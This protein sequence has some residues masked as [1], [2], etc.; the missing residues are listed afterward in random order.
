MLFYVISGESDDEPIGRI[1]NS[2]RKAR[3][4]TD[5]ESNISENDESPKQSKRNSSSMSKLA[6]S[7]DSEG[8]LTEEDDEFERRA[9]SPR[10]R[11]SITGFRPRDISDDESDFIDDSSEENI[12]LQNEPSQPQEEKVPVEH[13]KVENSDPFSEEEDELHSFDPEKP[14]KEG[15]PSLLLSNSLKGANDS[16]DGKF[17][18]KGVNS[19]SSLD[20]KSDL[21]NRMSMNFNSSIA[22]KLSSTVINPHV[23]KKAN[24]SSGIVCL[25]SPSVE[26][27]VTLLPLKGETIEI[28]SSSETSLGSTSTPTRGNS[29]NLIQPKIKSLLQRANNSAVEG[30]APIK[31]VSREYYDT[32]L[33][34]LSEL[35]T[36]WTTCEN[37]INTLGSKLP[38]KGK[39]MS[40]RGERLKAEIE[41]LA[42]YISTL[43]VD[44]SFVKEEKPLV[45]PEVPPMKLNA[46][47][48]E[49]LTNAANAI[50]P[51]HTGKVGMANFIAQKTL[52]IERLKVQYDV[53]NQNM[54]LT[55]SFRVCNRSVHRST[56]LSTH[57]FSKHSPKYSCLKMF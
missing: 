31:Y 56:K 34:K 32:Q 51:T 15:S 10:T 49:E 23:D 25:N 30:A 3:V 46:P 42:L 11:M 13:S 41:K 5:S 4:L 38:D 33:K 22:S 2:N 8:N 55:N 57:S 39:R 26:S 36:E 24:E 37:L 50:Q 45:K 21:P 1:K 29:K 19:R 35:K 52:T 18:R 54:T 14:P 9:L 44:D 40:G 48:W 43:K 12:V 47:S 53:R 17:Y 16:T 7:E 6:L 20:D 27:P 28:S